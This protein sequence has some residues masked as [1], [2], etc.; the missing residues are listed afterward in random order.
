MEIGQLMNEV[1][2]PPRSGRSFRVTQGQL[3]KVI[4]IQGK[5]VCDLFAFNP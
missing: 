5:Q 1:Y 4:D 2:V 3:L